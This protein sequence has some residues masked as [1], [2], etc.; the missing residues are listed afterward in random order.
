[1]FIASG[2]FN[3]TEDRV[4]HY[5]CTLVLYINNYTFKGRRTADRLPTYLEIRYLHSACMLRWSHIPE[6]ICLVCMWANSSL[7]VSE[8]RI[9][10]SYLAG[11]IWIVNG[12]S[13]ISAVRALRRSAYWILSMHPHPRL[14]HVG[15]TFTFTG[16]SVASFPC[17]SWTLLRQTP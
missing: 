5:R 15:R 4:E 12:R 14:Y 1:M 8:A 13:D 10:N 16:Q 11:I 2:D 7:C 17:A 6:T 9:V 3:Y